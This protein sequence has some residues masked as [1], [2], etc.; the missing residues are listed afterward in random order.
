[1]TMTFAPSKQ[2]VL[3]SVTEAGKFVKDHVHVS[4]K[5]TTDELTELIVVDGRRDSMATEQ[6]WTAEGDGPFELVRRSFINAIDWGVE[7]RW[8][9]AK[10]RA[11]SARGATVEERV[12]E[13][14]RG[15]AR[16]LAALGAV[17]GG[18]AAAPG[19]VPATIATTV[20]EFGW[21]NVR[22]VDLLLTIAAIHGHGEASVEERRAWLFAML[23]FGNGAVTGVDRMA[24]E[25]GKGV[26]KKATR[27]IPMK[28]LNA[29]N[30][31]VGRTIVTKYGTVRGVVA[32]GNAI[33]FGVGACIGAGGNYLTV[34][35]MAV[36]ANR[37]FSQPQRREDPED[38][39]AAAAAT[40]G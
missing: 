13:V 12:A 33:P 20:A 31:T 10:T 14:R 19:M 16:E 37:F 4:G 8:E 32:L 24:S 18:V 5:A 39:P 22:M 2:L 40:A 28:V 9:S 21:I 3:T 1:M 17:S 7:S 15:F 36:A 25:V 27:R 11:G 35:A 6:S 38:A 29:V 34:G 23:V 30:H 26:G